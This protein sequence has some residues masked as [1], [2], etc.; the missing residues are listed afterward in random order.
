MKKIQELKQSVRKAEEILNKMKGISEYEI[1][2]SANDVFFNRLNFTSHIPSNGVEEAK[3]NE[4]F[5]IGIQIVVNKGKKKLIGFG[6]EPTNISTSGIKVAIDKALKTAIYD[7]EFLSLPRVDI[8]T[9]LEHNFN[10]EKLSSISDEI[11]VESGWQIIDRALAE[12]K[13][14]NI[15]SQDNF[16]ING[17]VTIAES[18]GPVI[19]RGVAVRVLSKNGNRI[20]VKEVKE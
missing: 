5:G 3:S 7:P 2:V 16:I 8:K 14:N 12:F 18:C 1:F 10:D 4:D 6:S 20:I 11:K 19:N 13:K 15:L 17:D 9:K